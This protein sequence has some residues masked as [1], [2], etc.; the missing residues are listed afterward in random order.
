MPL[1][2][3]IGGERQSPFTDDDRLEHMR[4]HVER[5][6]GRPAADV[7]EIGVKDGVAVLT[8]QHGGKSHQLTYQRDPYGGIVWNVVGRPGRIVL[9]TS[10]KAPANLARA[11]D[12]LG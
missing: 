10:D 9:G 3:L 1:S 12:Q 11:L 2:D 7:G 6:F 4:K 5:A 8:V